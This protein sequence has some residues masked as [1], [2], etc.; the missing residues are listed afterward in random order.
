MTVDGW[1]GT[2][3]VRHVSRPL[4]AMVRKC[5]QASLTYAVF[6][7]RARGKARSFLPFGGAIGSSGP[8]DHGG[9][10]GGLGYLPQK[11]RI[12]RVAA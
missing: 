10:I 5:E 1:H 3:A 4:D 7:E 12:G 8:A 11:G 6:T 2:V 9:R